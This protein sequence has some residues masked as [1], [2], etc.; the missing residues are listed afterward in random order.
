MN[1]QRDKGEKRK[2]LL[3]KLVPVF[4]LLIRGGKLNGK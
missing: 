4:A 3:L 1:C 2:S